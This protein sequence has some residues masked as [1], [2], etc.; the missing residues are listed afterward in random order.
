SNLRYFGDY[1]LIEEIARGGMGVV[2]KARQRNL[3]R[4]VALKLMLS[5]QFASREA[6]ARFRTESLTAAKLR[7]PN[8]VPVYDVGE[9]N[10][11]PFIT[12]E[13][14]AGRTLADL[15]RDQ[16]LP[17]RRAAEYVRA[18]ADAVHYAHEQGILHRDL[19]PSNLLL[20]QFEQPRVTD[21]G[22]AKRLTNSELETP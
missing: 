19:K 16:P 4:V 2:F 5:G 9:A 6:V 20:D 3:D 15:V 13:F 1:E 8:I 21:F 12:M 18:I 17:A 22:L 11:Q 14:V 7:H 10:G